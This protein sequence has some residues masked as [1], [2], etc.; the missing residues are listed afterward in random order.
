MPKRKS[1]VR[2]LSDEVQG[3]GSWVIVAL[4]TVAEMREIRKTFRE[5]AEAEKDTFDMG[6]ILLKKYVKE[7]NW[8]FQDDQPMPQPKADPSIIEKLTDP[9]SSFLSACITGTSQDSKN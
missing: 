4:P 9:E 7:W 5:A 3:D 1:I 8:V 2:V 6:I